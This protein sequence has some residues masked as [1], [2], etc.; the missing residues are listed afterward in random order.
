MVSV[1]EEREDGEPGISHLGTCPCWVRGAP[2]GREGRRTLPC[3]HQPTAPSGGCGARAALGGQ[4][5]LEVRLESWVCEDSGWQETSQSQHRREEAR[6]S[7]RASSGLPQSSARG[8]SIGQSWG[9]TGPG[10]RGQGGPT[11]AHVHSPTL[12]APSPPSS[13]WV[14]VRPSQPS[15]QMQEKESPLPTQVPPFTQGLGRQLLFLAAKGSEI[16]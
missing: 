6:G 2:G 9:G 12:A 10:S 1:F 16:R 3:L 13:L 11:P 7:Q 4:P 8:G 5:I 15:R 14:Q